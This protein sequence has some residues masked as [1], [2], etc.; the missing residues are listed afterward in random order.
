MY[1]T[2]VLVSLHP[3]YFLGDFSLELSYSTAAANLIQTVLRQR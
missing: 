1:T 2:S 3:S